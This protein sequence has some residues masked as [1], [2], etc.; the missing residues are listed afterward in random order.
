VQDSPAPLFA[1]L[2]IAWSVAFGDC[3]RNGAVAVVVGAA[4]AECGVIAE[5]HE[6][7]NWGNVA[8]TVGPEMEATYSAE[9]MHTDSHLAGDSQSQVLD[10]ETSPFDLVSSNLEGFPSSVFGQGHFA[11]VEAASSPEQSS[12]A[13]V[14]AETWSTA[15]RYSVTCAGTAML[16]LMEV[17]HWYQQVE[18][19]YLTEVLHEVASNGDLDIRCFGLSV[20]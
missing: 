9:G 15:E 20:N 7:R 6:C 8:G 19:Q 5:V 12:C 4:I 13:E 3:C 16:A 17:H 18:G 10:L 11:G 2:N 1:C 14:F